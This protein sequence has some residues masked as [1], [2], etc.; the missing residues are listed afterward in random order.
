MNREGVRARPARWI[1]RL[2]PPFLLGAFLR[3]QG[4][5][6]QI[7]VEDEVHAVRSVVTQPWRRLYRFHGRDHCLPLS[8]WYRFLCD[9]GVEL[10][11]AV[12][13][14][15]S[16]AAGLLALVLLPLL[17]AR[18]A[19]ARVV[20][21]YAWLLALSPALVY[22]SRIA[23]PYALA[24]LLAAVAAA[25][26]WRWYRGGG[27]RWAVL[28]VVA[29]GLALWFHLGYAGFLAAAPAFGV[30]DRLWR[31]RSGRGA[32]GGDADE[33]AGGRERSLASLVAVGCGLVAAVLLIVLPIFSS[34]RR[35]ANNKRGAGEASFAAAADVL[36]LE[37]GSASWVVTVL[38]WL[39]AL[40]GLARL[41]RRRPRLALF[42]LALVVF[43]WIGILAVL[44]PFGI[45]QPLVLARYVLVALPVVFL[46]VALGLEGVG[47]AVSA[48]LPGARRLSR[49]SVPAAAVALLAATSALAADPWLRLGPFAGVK[50][51]VDLTEARR[52]LPPEHRPAVYRLV[53]E[54]PGEGAVVEAMT[55]TVS[56]HL[57]ATIGLARFH[58]RPVVLASGQPWLADPRLAF[59]TLLPADPARL[60]RSDARFVVVHR[61]WLELESVADEAR[62]A[63]ELRN[64]STSRKASRLTRRIVRGMT[65]QCG[66]PYLA[67]EERWVWDLAL[68]RATAGAG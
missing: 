20:T 46:W 26:F 33:P 14:A 22:Y 43:Q 57:D 40:A 7:L 66:Q 35:I 2:A 1:L 3:L 48:R 67:S 37:S 19:S 49:W 10:T 13:R 6:T 23:R 31:H 5:S 53:A 27:H 63:R 56:T 38:F 39:V 54:S 28:Y 59:R 61:H 55:T 52:V 42:G 8:A 11:E 21:V 29:G 30:A 17:V 65:R 50:A 47:E 44:R 4:L 64:T 32:D 41:L 60:C 18:G 15:P 25:A 16:V 62:G 24:V 36:R 68:W 51:S 9:R 58:R 45:H 34:F 12:L